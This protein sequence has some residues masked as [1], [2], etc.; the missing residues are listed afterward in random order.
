MINNQNIYDHCLPKDIN[1]G[2][3]PGHVLYL[4]EEQSVLYAIK[5]M[6]NHHRNALPV[7]S[8]A[9]YIGTIYLK[10]LLQ[11]IHTDQEHELLYHKLNFDMCT[12]LYMINRT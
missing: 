4:H 7:Y 6:I 10:D 5:F 3:M 9:E 11:L 12:A 1:I 2:L 8:E